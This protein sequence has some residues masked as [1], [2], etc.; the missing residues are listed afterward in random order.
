VY[1][2]GDKRSKGKKK[3]NRRS[4]GEDYQNSL[5]EFFK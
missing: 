5:Y 2:G 4:K 3:E 1:L